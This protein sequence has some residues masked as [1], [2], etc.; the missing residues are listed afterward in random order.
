MTDRRGASAEQ[1]GGRQLLAWAAGVGL[2][3]AGWSLYL[4]PHEWATLFPRDLPVYQAAIDAFSA[5]ADP[6]NPAQGRHAHGLFFTAPP[7]V[8]ELY[9]LA[10]HSALKPIFATVLLTA[11]AVSVVVLPLVLSRL[12]SGPGLGRIALGTG[13]FFTAFAG[14]GFFT[15]LVINNGTPLYALIA[16]ALIP[17]VTK[18]A[19]GRFTPP[20]CWRR[21][22]SPSTPPSGWSLCSPTACAAA[23]GARAP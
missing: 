11:D 18:T 4:T 5:G 15:A 23:S 2:L 1:D 21:R 6:Y 17:G 7:F 12:L 16:V 8:W 13:F 10:A 14:A 22:S 3:V 19:G 9:K 20:W